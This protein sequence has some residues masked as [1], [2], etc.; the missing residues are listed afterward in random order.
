MFL[1]T[2]FTWIGLK[3]TVSS[4]QSGYSVIDHLI[5]YGKCSS[6]EASKTGIVD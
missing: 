1:L 4:K 5:E 2:N 6:K 3:E